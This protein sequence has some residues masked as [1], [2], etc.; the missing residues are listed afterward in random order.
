MRT[1]VVFESSGTFATGTLVALKEPPPG[2]E[3]E[4]WTVIGS[5]GC[6]ACQHKAFFE[7]VPMP[8]VLERNG[9]GL[10]ATCVAQ[11]RVKPASETEGNPA[12]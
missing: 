9:D 1:P 2:R 4:R 6:G 3:A 7:A 11:E 12:S 8:L 5:C 10:V